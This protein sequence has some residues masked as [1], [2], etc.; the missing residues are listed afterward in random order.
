VP[1]WLVGLIPIAGAIISL[2]DTLLIFR[3]SHQCLHDQVAGTIVV[4]A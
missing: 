2:V 4:A 1:W 3:S